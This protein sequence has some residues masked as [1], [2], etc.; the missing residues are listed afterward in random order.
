MAYRSS[1]RAAGSSPTNLSIK[2]E[3]KKESKRVRSLL[4][5]NVILALIDFDH[6]FHA[7]AHTWW[8]R[9]KEDGWASCPL[10]ENGVVRI[11]VQPSYSSPDKY[12]PEDVIAWLNKFAQDTDHEFWADDISLLDTNRFD[13][14]HIFGPK[15]LTDIYLLGLA[16]SKGGRLITFDRKATPAAVPGA[17]EKNLFVII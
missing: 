8:N 14:K 5:I 4:D 2:S 7:L 1:H 10:T 16:A 12:S 15:Q 3:R 9:A 17:S 6:I 11:F 13:A